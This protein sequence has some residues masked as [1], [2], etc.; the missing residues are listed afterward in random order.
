MRSVARENAASLPD[1]HHSVGIQDP[2]F[3]PIVGICMTSCWRSGV[4]SGFS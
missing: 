4:A 2:D 1:S 3:I